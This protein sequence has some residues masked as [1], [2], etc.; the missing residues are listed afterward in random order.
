MEIETTTSSNHLRFEANRKRKIPGRF[1]PET[2]CPDFATNSKFVKKYNQKKYNRTSKERT[3]I[4]NLATTVN[5]LI[6]RGCDCMQT[7]PTEAH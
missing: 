5:K 3:K 1:E 2:N 4:H 6:D 7:R